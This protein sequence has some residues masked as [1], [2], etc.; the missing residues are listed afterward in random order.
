MWLQC[1]HGWSSRGR[2]AWLRPLEGVAG[3]PVCL[4]S[5]WWHGCGWMH[6]CPPPYHASTDTW[7]GRS[8]C[9]CKRWPV[10]LLSQP[11]S[12]QDGP[13]QR[14]TTSR[15]VFTWLVTT[16][17]DRLQTLCSEGGEDVSCYAVW[18]SLLEPALDSQT[19]SKVF[20]LWFSRWTGL[21][22]TELQPSSHLFVVHLYT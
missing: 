22:D 12:C 13:Y 5:H 7:G 18:Q 21:A 14:H 10:G 17:V 9:C 3:R 1:V 4:K 16:V 19:A 20:L 2:W 6:H 15:S 8:C 11:Q